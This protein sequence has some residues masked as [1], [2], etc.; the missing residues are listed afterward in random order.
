MKADLFD[1]T[2]KKLKSVDLPIQFNEDYDN[3]LVSRA[4]LAIRSH[5]I[6]PYGTMPRAG[7]NYSAKLSRRRRDYKGSYGKGIARVPRKTMWRRGMQFGWVGA[8]APG[9]VG[10]R[11]S[12]PPKAAK[13]WA[14]K[15]NDKERKKAIRSALSGAS[16]LAKFIV[17]EDK[18][19]TLKNTKEVKNVLKLLGFSIESVKRKRAGAGKSRGRRTRH[20][21]KALV[22]VSGKCD[23]VN[24]LS[25]LPGYDVVDV[26]SVNAA[27]LTVGVEKPRSC[28]FTDKALGILNK[29][30]LFLNKK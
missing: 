22:V 7:M 16:S 23:L 12:H 6:Q 15:I 21:L 2:G 17:I 8:L 19:E 26:R 25:N 13:I 30:G 10:G 28:I 20:G 3:D 11:K 4:V 24:A 14:L 29:E 9:T 18:F 5:N 27:L 1:L